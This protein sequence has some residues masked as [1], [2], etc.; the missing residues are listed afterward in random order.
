MLQGFPSRTLVDPVL[1][2]MIEA[3]QRHDGY[4][5]QSTDDGIFASNSRSSKSSRTG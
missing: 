1:H 5:A 4:V 2:I 3:A